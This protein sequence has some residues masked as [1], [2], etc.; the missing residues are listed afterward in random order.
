MLFC[1]K[2]IKKFQH[3]ESKNGL[4]ILVKN[5]IYF[6]TFTKYNLGFLIFDVK[7]VM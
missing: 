3:K 2:Y 7:V 5:V 1:I 4:V 6:R